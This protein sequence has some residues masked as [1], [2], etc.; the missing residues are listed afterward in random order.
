MSDLPI[1]EMYSNFND[2]LVK[3]EKI[4]NNYDTY[5]NNIK[6]SKHIFKTDKCVRTYYNYILKN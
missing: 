2:L 3:L 1:G 6:A 5:V 4:R